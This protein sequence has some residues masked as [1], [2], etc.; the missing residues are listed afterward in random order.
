[1]N[2]MRAPLGFLGRY[3]LLAAIVAALGAP[4]AHIGSGQYLFSRADQ[5]GLV[6]RNAGGPSCPVAILPRDFSLPQFTWHQSD[7]S[8][9]APVVVMEIRTLPCDLATSTLAELC[10]AS[11]C[12]RGPLVS[13]HCLLT[14]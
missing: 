11:S 14:I 2:I 9:T 3:V 10:P 12:N 13:L 4:Q 1:M 6:I 7:G 8:A 5:D